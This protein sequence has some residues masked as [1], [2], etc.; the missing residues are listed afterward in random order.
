MTVNEIKLTGT[1]VSLRLL[2]QS[3]HFNYY[4]L[5]DSQTMVLAMKYVIR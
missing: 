3:L 5:H 2:L 4:L 1:V